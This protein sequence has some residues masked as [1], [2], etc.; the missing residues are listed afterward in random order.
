[1][2]DTRPSPL[3]HKRR[4]DGDVLPILRTI[5]LTWLLTAM[6]GFIGQAAIVYFSVQRQG[7]L[8]QALTVEVKQLNANATTGGLKDAEHDF[9]LADHERRIQTLEV[10]KTP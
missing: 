10:R 3:E 4:E 5:P 8:I 2:S 1:M 7:E 9:R 6:A